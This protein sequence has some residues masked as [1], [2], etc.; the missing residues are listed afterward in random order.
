MGCDGYVAVAIEYHL[1]VYPADDPRDGARVVRLS[2]DNALQ[3]ADIRDV[4]GVGA[5]QF[6]LRATRSEAADISPDGEQ[7]V[8]VVRDDGSTELVVDGFWTNEIR[9]EAAVR[10]ETKRL[11]VG[12]AGRMAYLAR[13]VMAPHT[14]LHGV[15]AGF[16]PQDPFDRI[17]RLWNQGDAAGGDKLGAV[18]WRVLTEANRYRSGA[19]Y[20]HRHADG[21]TYTDAHDDDRRRSAIPDLTLGFDQFEDSDGNA[22]TMDSGEFTAMVGENVLQVV[23][24]LMESGLYVEMDPD[25]FELRAWEGNDHRR[26]RTGGAWGT[27]VVR[28][29]APTDGTIATGNI[30]SDSERLITSRIR[31]T[32]I[33][34]GG[35]GDVYGFADTA[36]G[37]PWEGYAPSDAQDVAA[38]DN[39]A[40]TQ[41][42]ARDEAGDVLSARLKLGQTPTQG[43]YLPWEHVKLDDVV[44]V[45]TGTAE[46]DYNEAEYPVAALRIHLRDGGDWDAWVDL[47]ASLEAMAQRQF[48]IAAAAAHTHPPNPQLCRPG[49]PGST[50]RLYFSTD[51]ASAIGAPNPA[52]AAN[53]DATIGN[54]TGANR[55]VLKTAPDG[56]ATNLGAG[57]TG[58]AG[59]NLRILQALYEL[60]TAGTLQGS[61][62]GQMLARGDSQALGGQVGQAQMVIRVVAPDGTTFRGTA[63][64]THDPGA[65]DS[66]NWLGSGVYTNRG[67]P[68]SGS[69]AD[70]DGATL[71]PVAY[72]A[73]DWLVVE[74]GYKHIATSLGDEA[75]VRIDSDGATD[76][77]ED[78]STLT[79]LNS[80][81]DI[82]TAGSSGDLP[83]DTVEQGAEAVG[84]STR[85]ARCDHQH[86]HGLLSPAQTH[87]HGIGQLQNLVVHASGTPGVTDDED[88]DYRIGTHWI[89][90]ATGAVYILIDQTAG[91]AEWVRL[92]N[93]AVVADLDDLSDV[94]ITAPAEDDELR[95]V[96]G[97]WINDPRKWEAV[98]NGEDV[99]VW[100]GDDLVHEW[101]GAP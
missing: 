99:F 61:V 40:D 39:L 29:Q 100:E 87:Y 14:Y 6:S 22:W 72:Q 79:S 52:A 75:F 21:E 95:Y 24:R 45:H 10:N 35:N 27:N 101:N 94:T 15:L 33:W 50:T 5:G 91:A 88:D 43:L 70:E 20:T 65:A 31:R 7:Y 2:A 84:T 47:G 57:T 68:A 49:A 23:R 83:L 8:R 82:T 3:S 34:A 37:T 64:D 90:D 63:L 11:T 41:M 42:A 89:D 16:T 85:A 98:T 62:R 54:G 76:L 4:I 55:K 28:L 56:T 67:F 69:W 86:A 19:T 80:W 71:T 44:T 59:D 81:I 93:I 66:P 26:T 78:E 9:Y 92:D 96:D 1:D 48:E 77:P 97:E 58:S 73:G 17:W 60:D 13:S 74:I 46:W 25:T 36:S 38:L 18:L 32:S 12:G 51:N 30:K 53:W